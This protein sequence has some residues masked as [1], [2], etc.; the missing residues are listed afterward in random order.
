M[1]EDH[2]VVNFKTRG[3]KNAVNCTYRFG[4]TACITAEL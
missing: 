4:Q 2:R 1:A 3:D